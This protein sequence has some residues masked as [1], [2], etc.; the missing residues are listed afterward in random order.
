MANKTV[1]FIGEIHSVGVEAAPG[2]NIRR[3]IAG[4]TDADGNHH[5]AGT[6]YRALS[7]G[8]NNTVMVSASGSKQ[9]KPRRETL[10]SLLG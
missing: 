10:V 9:R 1:T 4:A 2:Q 5:P 7:G 8:G 3:L 6:E